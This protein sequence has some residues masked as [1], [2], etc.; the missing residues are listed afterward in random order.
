[1]I[2]LGKLQIDE[3]NDDK[4]MAIAGCV[5]KIQQLEIRCNNDVTNNS[6]Q[7]LANAI[8]NRQNPVSK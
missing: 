1:M 3:I 4:M 6:V 5:H 8:M 2:K 7:G